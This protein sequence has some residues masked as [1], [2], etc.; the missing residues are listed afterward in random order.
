MV[1]SEKPKH[2]P[3]ERTVKWCGIGF[4]ACIIITCN[5]SNHV[6]AFKCDIVNGNDNLQGWSNFKEEAIKRKTYVC[7]VNLNYEPFDN[8]K[9]YALKPLKG[10]VESSWRTGFWYL[11]TK[12]DTGKDISYRTVVDNNGDKR[13]WIVRNPTGSSYGEDVLNYDTGYPRDQF[14]ALKDNLPSSDTLYYN[15]LKKDTI[16]FK[17]ENIKGRIRIILLRKK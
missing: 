7:D 13:H 14:E 8:D 16:D 17:P 10:W 3:L 9:S 5:L 15:V 6:D 4:I 1:K 12:K 11:T 2:S